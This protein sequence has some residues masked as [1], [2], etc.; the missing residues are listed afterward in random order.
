MRPIKLLGV[1]FVLALA[2]SA[3]AVTA[4][5]AASPQFYLSEGGVEP[6]TTI[7][8]T[9]PIG[10][11]SSLATLSAKVSGTKLTLKSTN[12]T[13][14]GSID[15]K[16]T[17]ETGHA[18][19]VKIH[20]EG[21]TIE[22]ASLNEVCSVEDTQNLIPGTITTT[23][24]TGVAVKSPSIGVSFTG[25]S[26]KLADLKFVNKTGKECPLAAGGELPVEGTDFAS[27]VKDV[28]TSEPANSTLTFAGGTAKFE[29]SYTI[30][31]TGK[32]VTEH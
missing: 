5:L 20:F 30:T 7:T 18:T 32:S 6:G 10:G 13:A 12:S 8:G 26:G 19:G 14:T 25:A 4:A 23:E 17:G 15:N 3:V 27:V 1:S 31:S 2:F 11:T 24:L 9:E 16:G 22:P 28:L 29:A 21:V